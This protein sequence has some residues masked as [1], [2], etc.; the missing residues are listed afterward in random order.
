MTTEQFISEIAKYI[1][2]YAPKYNI[3]I[4]SPIIAQ[5]IL[6]SA[7][8]TSELAINAN[9][10]FGLKYRVGRCP[11]ACGIYYKVGSEQNSDGSHTSSTM[12]WMKFSDMENGV[13]GYFD[14]TNISNYSNLK[15]VSDPETYLKNI[16]ADGYATSFNYVDNLMSVIKCYN[17]TKY[18][19]SNTSQRGQMGYTNS[20]LVNYTKISPNKTSPRNHKIDTI[21]IHHMAGNL[22]V[23]TCGNV[24]APTSRKA[25]S[26]YGIGSDGRI[27][28]YVDEKDRS[29]CTGN[30]ANDNRA[31]TIEVANNSGAPDWHVSDKALQSLINLVAD[32]CRRNDIKSLKWQGDKALIG[33][34]DK[35]NMTVHRWFQATNCPGNYLYSKQSYIAGEVN[36]KLGNY[37]GIIQTPSQ[38]SAESSDIYS[39]KQFIKDVQTAIGAK[40][41]GIAGSETLSKTVTVSKTKNNKHA[42]VKP[43]QKYFNA[44]G[45]NCGIVDGIAGAKFDVAVK[46]YQRANGCVVD[47][48]VTK[49]KKTWKSLLGLK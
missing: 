42:V 49:G 29:W 1:Q 26:N 37:S 39:H 5:A 3:K 32:I 22:S 10:Y 4:H 40:V 30:A 19:S 47:G 33:N 20:S 6:E 14:F 45:Y 18:D 44:L 24:F 16:K 9:N 23:E 38:V 28:L 17:L 31:I 25:S 13:I 46:A 35:Q 34:I 21:T 48:E 41:D 43:L 36:K 2:K 12:Q 7:R 15:G 27:G 11:T 8:G